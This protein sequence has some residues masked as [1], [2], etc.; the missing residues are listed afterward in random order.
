[1]FQNLETSPGKKKKKGAGSSE[2]IGPGPDLGG[3]G[4][5]FVFPHK[6][7]PAG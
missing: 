3:G 7:S 1:M 6:L 4:N 2:M 5:I